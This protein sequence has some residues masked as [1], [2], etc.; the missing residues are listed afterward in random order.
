VRS[1]V[2][3]LGLFTPTWCAR[4]SASPNREFWLQYCPAGRFG[5]VREISAACLY[6]AST[7]RVS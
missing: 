1:N 2:L 5:E 7:P 3:M 4:A 6:L